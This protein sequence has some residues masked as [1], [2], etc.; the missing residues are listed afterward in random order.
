[1]NIFR[2]IYFSLSKSQFKVATYREGILGNYEIKREAKSGPGEGG[3]PV[4]TTESERRAGQAGLNRYGF[5][6]PAS[7]KISYDRKIKDTRQKEY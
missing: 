5:N 1:M 3:T 7:E 4:L 6:L 2:D